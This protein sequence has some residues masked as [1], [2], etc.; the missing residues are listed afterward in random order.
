[1]KLSYYTIDDLRLGYDPQGETG[2][3]QS[4]FLDLRDALE[5]YRSLPD[6][7]V[8]AI[9][10]SNGEQDVELARRLP[11]GTDGLENVLVLDFLALPLWK[12]EEGVIVSARELVDVLDI[13][14]CLSVDKLVPPPGE[15]A[16]SKRLKGKYLWPDVPGV[17]ESAIRW[18][19]LSGVGWVPPKELKRRFPTPEKNYQYP[20]VFK[21]KVDGMTSKGGYAPLEV[22]HWEY[23]MLARR[24]QERL[25]H[26]KK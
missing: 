17:F 19:Y 5:Q 2:W 12:K 8:K 9:G 24:T 7:A 6:D 21:Y 1:M 10:V 11:V 22:S 14:W 15:K 4:C 18:V 25:D 26:K 16:L 23:L 13:R 20:T 3:R